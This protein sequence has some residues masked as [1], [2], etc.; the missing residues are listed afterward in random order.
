MDSTNDKPLPVKRGMHGAL[1]FF[2]MSLAGM[3]LAAFACIC[4]GGIL[5]AET[6]TWTWRQQFKLSEIIFGIAAIVLLFATGIAGPWLKRWGTAGFIF[7][8]S[9]GMALAVL[10]VELMTMLQGSQ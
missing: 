10:T 8:M 2:L 3:F 7:G 6:K 4:G 1:K 5:G 9:A